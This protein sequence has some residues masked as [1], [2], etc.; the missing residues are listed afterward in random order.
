[1]TK[2][3][4]VEGVVPRRVKCGGEAWFDWTDLDCLQILLLHFLLRLDFRPL[5]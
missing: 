5:I 1:M 4:A 2:S 3:M